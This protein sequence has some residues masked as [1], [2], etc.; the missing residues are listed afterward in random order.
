ME[1]CLLN[2]PHTKRASVLNGK[3]DLFSSELVDNDSTERRDSARWRRNQIH[4]EFGTFVLGR[5]ETCA[6]VENILCSIGEAGASIENRDIDDSPFFFHGLD[7]SWKDNS[8]REEHQMIWCQ[9]INRVLCL[10]IIACIVRLLLDRSQ[11]FFHYLSQKQAKEPNDQQAAIRDEAFTPVS[12]ATFPSVTADGVEK[13]SPESVRTTTQWPT[14]GPV[15][16]YQSSRS[17]GS[18]AA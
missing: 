3:K 12:S 7:Q 8:E 11:Q 14:I 18:K 6:P 9:R 1:A 15:F 4:S 5:L 13:K 2:H 17:S 16:V 10:V